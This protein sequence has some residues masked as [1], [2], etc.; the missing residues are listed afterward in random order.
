MVFS[1]LFKRCPK[2]GKIYGINKSAWPQWALMFAGLA[3]CVWYLFR[4]IPK[5]S[6]AAYPCQRA[7]APLRIGF[8]TYCVALAGYVFAFAKGKSFLRNKKY[9]YAGL[10]F[11]VSIVSLF[12]FI[13]NDAQ[14]VLAAGS[15]VGTPKGIFPGRVA[16]VYNPNAAKWTG[17]GNYWAA[18]VNPQA[19]YNKSFTAGVAALSGGT[20]DA[21][22]WGKI[23]RWFNNTHGRTGTGY[24]AGDMIAIKINQNNSAAP[25]ADHGNAMNTNP[26]TCVAVVTSLVNAGVP[27]ADIWIG[28]PSRAVTDNIF[29]AIHN[30]FPN[31]KVVDYFGNNGRVT[32]GVTNDVFPNTDVKNAESTCFYNARYIICQPLLKG[33]VGQV[34]TFGSKNFYGING[35]LPNWQDNGGK[36]P[37]DDALTKYMTNANFGGKV[38]LWCMDAMYPS[39]ALDGAPY[40][41]VALTPFNGKQM[42]SF[43]MSLDGVAEECVSYDFWS[44][45]SGQ[46]GGIDY[47]NSAATAGAGVADHWNNSTAKQYAKNLDP[48]A[49]GIELVTVRPGVNM[50]DLSAFV[51]RWLESDC[52]SSN[53]YCSGADM[54][55]SGAVDMKDYALFASHWLKD[56]TS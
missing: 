54:D 46:S 26:Q 52:A 19:E 43:I 56:I 23:F 10:F 35:I 42:S 38:V 11:V 28:D 51:Q 44:A 47:I 5:P 18:A 29:N 50:K 2:T 53:D 34:I 13:S 17:A 3:A 12:V 39:P 45:I 48:N 9:L 36:H 22:S 37:G 6:R 4:V 55:A 24:L 7:A 1:N 15:P 20:S 21:N 49:N 25:A 33:H 27:Q 30:V 8:L 40:N 14:P 16:W 41:G 32:T 31:V